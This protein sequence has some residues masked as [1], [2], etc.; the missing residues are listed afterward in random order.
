MSRLL[1]CL[2]LSAGV[3]AAAPTYAEEAKKT[4]ATVKVDTVTAVA[5][6]AE[7]KK[8]KVKKHRK[9][10]S[11]EIAASKESIETRHKRMMGNQPPKRALEP[12]EKPLEITEPAEQ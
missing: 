4:E 5:K 8:A 9:L 12:I 3:L 2:L 7:V 11:E 6:P 10:T 1:L